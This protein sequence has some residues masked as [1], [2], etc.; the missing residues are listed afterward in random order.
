MKVAIIGAGN[1]GKALGTSIV[2]A[3]HEVVISARSP[4]GAGDAATAIG[5]RAASNNEDAVRDADLV[6]LAV[7]Y[8]AE[9]EVA[10]ELRDAVRDR[11]VVDVSNPLKPDL[12]GLAT[13]SSAAAEL[14]E[15]LPDAKVVKAFNTVFASNHANPSEVDVFIAGDDEHAKARVAE[16]ADGIGFR[17]LDVGPIAMA[18]PLEEMA[19]LNIAVNVQNGWG[20]TSAWKLER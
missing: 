17:T 9:P 4:K 3:G 2:R 18:R 7:P 5:A 10:E 20:W 12:S 1:V 11:V 15:R 8:S 16:L 13:T 14:Q 6:I 19:F